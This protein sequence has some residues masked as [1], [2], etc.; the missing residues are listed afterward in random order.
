MHS[1]NFGYTG[2]YAK[3]TSTDIYKYK[4]STSTDIYNSLIGERYADTHRLGY[5]ELSPNPNETGRKSLDSPQ[6]KRQ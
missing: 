5:I 6:R 3:Y 1:P 4:K 2:Q